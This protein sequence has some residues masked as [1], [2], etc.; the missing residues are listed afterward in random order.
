MSQT[1]RRAFSLIE[2]LVVLTV[3]AI[4]VAISLSA[5]QLVRETARRTSNSMCQQ[6]ASNFVGGSAIRIRERFLPTWQMVS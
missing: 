6:T 3:I 1:T 2:L 4:L 5:V